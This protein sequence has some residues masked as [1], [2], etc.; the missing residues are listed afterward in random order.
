MTRLRNRLS[1][2]LA[3]ALLLSCRHKAASRQKVSADEFG[4]AEWQELSCGK[5]YRSEKGK[6]HV[7]RIDL[8]NPGLRVVSYP[9]SE[10]ADAVTDAGFLGGLTLPQFVRKT[11]ATVAVNT[12]PYWINTGSGAGDPKKFKILGIHSDGRMQF[13]KPLEKYPALVLYRTPEGF[14]AK[15]VENQTEASLQDADFAFGGYFQILRGGLKIDFP[16]EHFDAR[17]AVGLG[18]SGDEL[19][20]L[21]CRKSPGLSFQ[22]CQEIFLSLGCVDALE[23][24][25]GSS[26]SFFFDAPGASVKIRS[27]LRVNASYMGFLFDD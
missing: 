19:F 10:D 5:Y 18:E 3:C 13:S 11:G 1:F 8:K 14:S 22:E 15:I 20:L 27:F 4:S 6:I 23:F 24:D 16:T 7:I 12:S 26:T 17:T 2:C 25:G 21:A 9:S